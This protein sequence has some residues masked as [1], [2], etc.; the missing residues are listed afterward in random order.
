MKDED[1]ADLELQEELHLANI[2]I[3]D[4]KRSKIALEEQLKKVRQSL[5]SNNMVSHFFVCVIGENCS[6]IHCFWS[7]HEIVCV[8]G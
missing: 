6:V 5:R 4:L 1:E 2:H 3:E 7:P 8:N